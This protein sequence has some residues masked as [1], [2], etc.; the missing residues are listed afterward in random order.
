MLAPYATG[1]LGSLSRRRQ[2]CGTL[3][4]CAVALGPRFRGG[5]RRKQKSR[6]TGRVG[7]LL[8]RRGE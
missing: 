4:I 7:R 1:D 3:Q 6:P 2:R 5:E 8:G